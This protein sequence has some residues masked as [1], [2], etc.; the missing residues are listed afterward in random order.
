MNRTDE[1]IQLLKYLLNDIEHII[2]EHKHTNYVNDL[3]GLSHTIILRSDQLKG[4]REELLKL[5]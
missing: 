4:Y 2:E 3:L 5:K 1:V